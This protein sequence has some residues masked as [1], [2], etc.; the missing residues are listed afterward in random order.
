MENGNTIKEMVSVFLH[1][2]Q[3]IFILEIGIKIVKM[4]KALLNMQMENI[5]KANFKIIKK[6]EMEFN[7]I[8]MVIII[9]DS[10]IIMFVRGKE[11]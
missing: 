4:E 11:L 5:I 7:H 10:G 6:K 3:E 9:L 1:M 2:K 8:K